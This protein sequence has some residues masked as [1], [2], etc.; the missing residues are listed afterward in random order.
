MTEDQL[1]NKLKDEFEK[2]I[3]NNNIQADLVLIKSRSLSPEEA[4]GITER[5]D[6][7][8]LTGKEVMLQAEYQGFYGQA[9]TDAPS[10]FSGTLSQI[11]E[12]DLMNDN[13]SRGLFISTMNA[14]MRKLDL[15][16]HTIHC[17][18]DGPEL[19]GKQFV[20]YMKDHYNNPKIALI[21]YQPSILENL[22]AVFDLRVLD[23]N[24]DNV[25]Q[26]RYCIKVEH[27]INDYDEVINW[28]DIILCTG[29]T[30][31]NGTI[32]NFLNLNKD[33]LFFGTSI[34]GA[35]TILELK[36]V[37]FESE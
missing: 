31:C 24:P 9:F 11:L 25:G 7:P 13:H 34:A 6:F 8:I 20:P 28:A 10:I 27:G 15:A 29:S 2:I 16:D 22:A 19:C 18:N 32:V 37:C 5:K 23:L 33:V 26:L 12:L 36:R 4:I 30:I 21:G 35:A 17:K 1:Y 3:I 14:V